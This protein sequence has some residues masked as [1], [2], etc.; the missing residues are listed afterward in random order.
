MTRRLSSVWAVCYEHG[1]GV[2]KDE[3][4][5]VKWYRKAAEQNQAEAQYN[6]G[7]CYSDGRGVAKDEVEAVKWWR[8][9]AEQN[10]ATL[11]TIWESVT[12]RA[13]AWRRITWRR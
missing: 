9:A 2:A 10:Y 12:T 4:E 11:N 7:G 3:V 1:H 6:L 8:K 13:K 5:A